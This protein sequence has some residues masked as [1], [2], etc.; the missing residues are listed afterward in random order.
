M[1]IGLQIYSLRDALDADYEGTLRKVKAMGYEGVEVY[2]SQLPATETKTLFANI[3]LEII[4][5]H[6][7]LAELEH[8]FEACVARTK[9][10]GTNNLICA[11]SMPTP[12]QSWEDILESLRTITAQAKA[13]G[14]NFMY[15]N[16]DHEIS[17]TVQGQRVM[18]AIMEICNVEI[19]VAWL[20]VGGLEAAQYLEQN[21]AK[22]QLL[23]IKDVRLDGEVWNTVELGKGSV[24]LEQC[25]VA[26]AK[27]PSLWLIVEQDHSPHPMLSAERNYQWLKQQSVN[28]EF[29]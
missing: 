6:F 20:R 16:H 9:E 2:G 19:D 21:A 24:P 1:K 3:G 4:G 17:Q 13:A 8:T 7:V 10:I 5:H 28:K 15:H 18:D 26:A 25:L 23:H 27:T 11:W 29:S 14:I 12:E 22:A